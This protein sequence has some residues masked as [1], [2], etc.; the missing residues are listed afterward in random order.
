MKILNNAKAILIALIPLFLLAFNASNKPVIDRFTL[1]TDESW[2]V[3]K[4]QPIFGQYALTYNAYLAAVAGLKGGNA[5]AV[6]ANFWGESTL[7]EGAKPIWLTKIASD[8]F[9]SRQ[10]KKTFTL[11]NNTIQN[12]SIKI[13]CDDAARVYINGQLIGK[14]LNGDLKTSYYKST[15][16]KQLTAYFYNKIFTY[17]IKSNLIVGGLNTIIVEVA[18]EPVNGGHAYLCA[19]LDVDFI[20]NNVAIKP[21]IQPVVKP[22]IKPEKKPKIVEK[23]PVEK[24]V[25]V[26]PKKEEPKKDPSVQIVENQPI[27][28]YKPMEMTEPTVFKTSNDVD[29]NKLKIGDV[30]ELG[31]IYFKADDWRLNEASQATLLELSAFLKANKSI[32]IEIGGHTNL[33]ATNEYANKLSGERAKSVMDFLVRSGVFNYNLTS[34][35]YGKS[36]PKMNEKTADAN[37]KNQRVEVKILAK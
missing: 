7:V 26:T 14:E 25:I 6:V 35:G 22:T 3:S 29:V 15:N 37:Q 23:K 8:N 30:F 24:V 1:I 19:R 5:P 18:S 27:N 21:T 16:Y 28:D 33:I 12:A 13:N 17:D 4:G 20:E 9:E 36:K 34:K 2:E 32:K 31:N 11:L 10:F